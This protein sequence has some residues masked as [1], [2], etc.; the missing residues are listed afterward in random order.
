MFGFGTRLGSGLAMLAVAAM[1]SGCGSKVINRAPVEDRG[2]A[3][4]KATPGLVVEPAT[5]AVKQPPGFENAGKPGYYTVKPVT[6]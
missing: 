5:Q 6:P 1:L 4:G 2:A 3:V